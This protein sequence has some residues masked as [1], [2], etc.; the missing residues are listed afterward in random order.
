MRCTACAE[1]ASFTYAG[2]AR[3]GYSPALS[4]QGWTMWLIS[5]YALAERNGHDW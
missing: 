4:A 1:T 3:T 2:I 5:E